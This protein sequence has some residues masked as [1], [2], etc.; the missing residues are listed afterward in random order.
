M[1]TLV[2]AVNTR[3]SVNT[4]N[5]ERGAGGN[6]TRTLGKLAGRRVSLIKDKLHIPNTT[7]G[8]ALAALLTGQ[9]ATNSQHSTLVVDCYGIK[10]MDDLI[11]LLT[12]ISLAIRDESGNPAEISPV[13]QQLLDFGIDRKIALQLAAD[14]WVTIE[15]VTTWLSYLDYNAES[16]TKGGGV[17]GMLMS[18][19]R[20]HVEAPNNPSLQQPALEEQIRSQ[21][22]DDLSD[23]YDYT[24][25]PHPDQ[26]QLSVSVEPSGRSPA[27]IWQTAYGELQ[28]QMPRETFD[29]WLRQAR[30]VDYQAGIYTIGV[31]NSYAQE[32]LEHR[33]RKVVERTLSQVA[34]S[35]VEVRFVVYA[36]AK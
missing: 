28:L 33:L 20:D 25:L 1:K 10:E 19:L 22:W 9:P 30:L 7:P 16:F 8:R 13:L 32:W 29:T 35:A 2:C 21:D 17:R 24:P 11:A 5:M 15:R 31:Q 14:P 3:N 12:T 18:R 6:P 27:T 36:D 26:S 23:E 34:E 4:N